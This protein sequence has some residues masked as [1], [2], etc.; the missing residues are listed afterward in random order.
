MS[1]ITASG[2][3][4]S[5]MF[6]SLKL[7]LRELRGGVRGFGVFLACLAIGVTAI[8]GVGSFARALSDGMLREGGRI[9]G[10]DISFSLIHRQTSTAE[11]DFLKSRG[12]VSEI[13]SM[14]AMTR[15]T[16]GAATLVELKAVD[17]NYPLDGKIELDPKVPLPRALQK[18]GNRYG[19]VAEP[20]LLLRLG[21]TPGAE[22]KIGDATFVIT[23]SI[24]SEPDRVAAGVGFGPRLIVSQEGLQATG[25]VQ[26]GSLVRWSYRVKLADQSDASLLST[27]V[28][29]RDLFPNAGWEIRTRSSASPQLERNVRRLA[30]FLT[31]VGLTALLVGGVGV[32]N[33][34][35]HYLERKRAD[36]ATFKAVGA[37]GGTVFS[38]YLAEI[39]I[40]ALIGISIGVV[41][42][43]AIP[44]V[45]TH[46]FGRAIPLPLAPGIHLSVIA[47]SAAF[48]LLVALAFALW[49]L[50]RAHDVPVSALFRDSV[51]QTRRFPRPRYVV[52]VV[53]AIVVLAGLALLVAESRRIALIYIVAAAAIFLVLRL[54]AWGLMAIAVK[55]PRPRSTALRLALANIHRPGALTPSVV[56]SLGL[57]LALLVTLTLIDGNLRRQLTQALPKSAPSFF[58]V[59]IPSTDVERFNAFVKQAAPDAEL[60]EVPMLRGRILKVKEVPAEQVKPNSEQ[61]WVLQSDRG[62][63]YTETLPE[64]SVLTEGEWWP[65]DYSGPPLVSFEKRAADG[66]G[67]RVGDKVS[68]NVLGRTIE[69][70]IANLRTVE[71]ESLGI[72]FVM[73]FSPNTFRGAPHTILATLAYPGGGNQKAEIELQRSVASE[74]PAVT[75][76][77]VK[78]ALEAINTLV[79]DIAVAVRGASAVTLIASILVL[80]GALAA[81]HHS[82]VYDAVILKTLGATRAR[83]VFAYGIEYAILGLATAI[84]AT[85]A[86]AVAAWFVVENVMN[87]RFRFEPAAAGLAALTA[88]L[89]T[90]GLGLIGT[91]RALGQKPAPVLRNL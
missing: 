62:I 61:A 3:S 60:T 49:P 5:R 70:T 79:A 42:G 9:L 22:I 15:V 53:A 23:A 8:A 37:S 50:G 64:G 26:P 2:A 55:L 54:L 83:L 20:T 44:F 46:F 6:V 81:G 24:V 80:A 29:A 77:R 7:A 89:L 4:P 13:A 58:F 21:V 48:G 52:M 40:I 16:N 47:L 28:Q 86:G 27:Q 36:I 69:A 71:W 33:A 59:D 51:E 17:A 19:A 74:F 41:L 75:A 78:E 1:A 32:A 88:V 31:L 11:M 76:V 73:L 34:V 84:F 72:N 63:T 91:W 57:G 35:M 30:E 56:L 67:L 90:I 38:I 87:F 10:G 66:L 14:R 82:R 18:V 25:L 85:A 43:S 65:K 68:V 45:V 39:G 12:A